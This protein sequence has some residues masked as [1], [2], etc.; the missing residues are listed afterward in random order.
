MTMILLN[1]MLGL[2]QKHFEELKN[3]KHCEKRT[4]T[5][6]KKYSENIQKNS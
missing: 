1:S 3:Q 6:L 5:Y 4:K 2:K